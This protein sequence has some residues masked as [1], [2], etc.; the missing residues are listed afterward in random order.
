[1][2]D[3]DLICVKR[4]KKITAPLVNFVDFIF[5]MLKFM[6][7][8]VAQFVIFMAKTKKKYGS[9]LWINISELLY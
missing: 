1:M 8:F 6:H 3:L 9:K 7:L 4:R 5:L 2:N